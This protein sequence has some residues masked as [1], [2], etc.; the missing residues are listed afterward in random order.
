MGDVSGSVVT[1]GDV[2]GGTLNIGVV[3]PPTAAQSPPL[4]PSMDRLLN[5]LDELRQVVRDQAPEAKQAQAMEKVVA[6]KSV[7]TE[8]RP[9]LDVIESVLR[10]F[11]TELP[12]LS[13]AVFNVLGGVE[14]RIK[15]ADEDLL[16]EFR[17]RFGEFP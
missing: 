15:E 3:A 5:L 12:Q 4:Q 7:A 16:P 13:G 8:K 2:S 6:L 17:R 10:W 9:D 1:M 14:R 11:E